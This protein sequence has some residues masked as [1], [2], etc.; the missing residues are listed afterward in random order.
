MESIN[1]KLI[2]EE[3]NKEIRRVAASLKEDKLN[4]QRGEPVDVEVDAQL[5]QRKVHLGVGQY[6]RQQLMIDDD[7]VV[8]HKSNDI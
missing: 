5:Y 1:E 2:A 8:T 3:V 6:H 7:L 4:R